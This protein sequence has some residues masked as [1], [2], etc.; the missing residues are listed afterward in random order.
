MSDQTEVSKTEG[1]ENE[2]PYLLMTLEKNRKQRKGMKPFLME[3]Q[4]L[5]EQREME[6]SHIRQKPVRR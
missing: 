6:I 4:L 3:W 1:V 2:K 5:M